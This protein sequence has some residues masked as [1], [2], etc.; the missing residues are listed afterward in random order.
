MP[1]PDPASIPITTLAA[2]L[3]GLQRPDAIY[4]E[5]RAL[6]KAG[7]RFAGVSWDLWPRATK[8][9]AGWVFVC[10]HCGEPLNRVKVGSLLACGACGVTG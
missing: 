6:K 1:T 9:D 10:Q 3:S 2:H 4:W 7:K 8:T 5:T